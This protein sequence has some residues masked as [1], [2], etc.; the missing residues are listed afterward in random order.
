MGLQSVGLDFTL[1]TFHR[2]YWAPLF[3]YSLTLSCPVARSFS[4]EFGLW[5][6]GFSIR[7]GFVWI[8]FQAMM[9]VSSL[10]KDVLF[11]WRKKHVIF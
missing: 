8:S 4:V 3:S 2:G 11:V 10:G 5:S 9:F 1:A 7:L 6:V